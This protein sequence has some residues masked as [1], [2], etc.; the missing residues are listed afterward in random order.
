MDSTEPISVGIE[1][2]SLG[3]PI[4]P[5]VFFHMKRNDYPLNYIYIYGGRHLL[6][7]QEGGD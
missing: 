4:V 3:K 6:S 2:A 5:V 7:M 1:R